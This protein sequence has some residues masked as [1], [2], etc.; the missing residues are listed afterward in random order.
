LTLGS[1]DHPSVNSLALSLLPT[2]R[3]KGR[4]FGALSLIHAIAGSLISPLIFGS[5]FAWTVGWY[6]PTAFAL[7]G[8]MLLVAECFLLMVRL[9]DEN[10]EKKAE[11]GR[12]RRVK[13]V[14]SSSGIHR[15]D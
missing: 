14:R 12:S 11:R 1:A 3:E 15:F 2:A 6:A 10:E 5:V 9:P 13:K 8:I 4:L 7:S